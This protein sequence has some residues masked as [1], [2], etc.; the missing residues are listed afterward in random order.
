ME[1]KY[2]NI[3]IKLTKRALKKDEVPVA[4][5]IVKED[6]IIAKSYNKQNKSHNI[7]NHAEI[8]AIKKASRKVKDWRL[9]ECDLYV[10]LKPCSMCESIINQSRIKNVYYLLDKGT[11]KKEYY[12]TKYAKANNSMQEQAYKNLLSSFF[13]KKR[14][15]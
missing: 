9:P 13:K 6:K 4:A 11:N 14:D 2:Y 7:I 12:K 3:L 15:K 1:E 5:I 10:T 8:Q